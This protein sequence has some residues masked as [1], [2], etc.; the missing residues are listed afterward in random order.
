MLLE[1]IHTSRN[2][3]FLFAT[4][5]HFAARM[6]QKQNLL[7]YFSPVSRSKEPQSSLRRSREVDASDECETRKESKRPRNDEESKQIGSETQKVNLSPEQKKL[8]ESK[9]QQAL[10]KLKQKKSNGLSNLIGESWYNKLQTEFSKDYFI[11]LQDFVGSE[12]KM[13]TVYP[14]ESDVF[15]W[16][17]LCP[18]NKVK[19]VIIGQDP[20]HGPR[21]AHGLC[22]SV[23]VGVPP[24]PSLV[25]IFKEMANDIDGFQIPDH[26]YLAGWAQQGVLLLNAVLTV[27]AHNANSHQ[28]K[29]WEAFTDAVIKK[30]NSDLSHVV[31]LL[32]GSYAQKKGASIDKKRHCILKGPHP[33][34]LS[35]HRG[36]FGCKHFSQ[37]NKYL[38]EHGKQEINWKHLP[39]TL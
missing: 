6:S 13:K 16:T 8:I 23:R 15:S 2:L 38:R 9:R 36:F 26:G 10:E 5:S 31:F 35:A 7:S 3:R 39:K 30:I 22:F 32:W 33:S 17:Q 4:N 29:G 37:A 24:P 34:P 19:V 14:P 11:K 12:R 28:G 27:V 25:N 21:Q 18:I 1:Y 20:Y